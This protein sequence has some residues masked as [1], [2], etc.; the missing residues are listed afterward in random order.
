MA[1]ICNAEKVRPL[2]DHVTVVAPTP[3]SYKIDAGYY[4]SAEDKAQAETIQKAVNEAIEAYKSWQGAK[5]GRDL[6]PSKLCELMVRAGARK[7][8][9]NLPAL[10][11]LSDSEIAVASDTKVTFKGVDDG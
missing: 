8:S 9:V 5:L 1:E 6:D 11:V 2:T 7:V 4:I 3:I 10:T